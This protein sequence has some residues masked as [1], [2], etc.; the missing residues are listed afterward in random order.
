[1]EIYDYRGEG[2][3]TVLRHGGWR[4][5][6]L[7][8]AD[9]FDRITYLERHLLTDEAF[10]LLEGEATLLIGETAT[11]VEM[12]PHKVYNIKQGEWHNIRVSRDAHV[13]IVENVET[14]RENS[15]YMDVGK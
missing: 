7:N 2:Y 15:E 4:V 1:M 10:I 11:P 5:A 12:E 6:Y 14:G 8:Y 3:Q 13:L 9:R